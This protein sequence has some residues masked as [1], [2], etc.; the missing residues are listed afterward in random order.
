MTRGCLRVR[1]RVPSRMYTREHACS[2]AR[3][4]RQCEDDVHSVMDTWALDFVANRLPPFPAE[5][6]K[7]HIPDPAFTDPSASPLFCLRVS[8]IHYVCVRVFEGRTHARTH[9]HGK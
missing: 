4:E 9:A 2:R 1:V 6:S 3:N 8:A 7:F 5:R